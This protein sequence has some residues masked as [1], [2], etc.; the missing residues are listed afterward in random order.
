MTP[1]NGNPSYQQLV[2]EN[3]RLKEQLA[4]KEKGVHLDLQNDRVVLRDVG[5]PQLHVS[6]LQLKVPGLAKI[7]NQALAPE[8]ILNEER[9]LHLPKL[10]QFAKIPMT[11]ERAKVEVAPE[12]INGVLSD[13]QVPGVSDL[14]VGVGDGGKLSLSGYA[15]KIFTVPFEITGRVT[16]DDETH[17]RFSLDKT[18]VA[19]FLPVPNL[20]TNIFAALAAD[21]MQKIH[22]ERQGNDYVV[23]VSGH[24]PPNLDLRLSRVTTQ[25]GKL[26]MEAD[27][28][29]DP[30]K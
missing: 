8:A 20:M 14:S 5:G 1:L 24:I 11:V 26:V 7:A 17:L 4:Q 29:S 27:G 18:K 9:K 25:D 12:V 21:Q 30:K 23:D 22:V 28:S 6:E 16:R 10:D 19:G 15:K 13:L 2:D 3:R